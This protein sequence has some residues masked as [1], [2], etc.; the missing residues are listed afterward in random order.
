VNEGSD[1]GE[2]S[3]GRARHPMLEP[4]PCLAEHPEQGQDDRVLRAADQERLGVT[5]MAEGVP[6]HRPADEERQPRR[7]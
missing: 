2:G 1:A 7:P 5:T 6:G 3:G 4:P